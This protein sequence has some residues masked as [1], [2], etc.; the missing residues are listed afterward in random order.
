MSPPCGGINDNHTPLG[1][2]KAV[3]HMQNDDEDEEYETDG[4]RNT[5]K[6]N[7]M[8]T[9]SCLLKPMPTGSMPR[10]ICNGAGTQALESERQQGG[11]C[12]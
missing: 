1:S 12:R 3:D 11:Q 6:M 9:I 8:K 7:M 4:H 2:S 10:A 5:M